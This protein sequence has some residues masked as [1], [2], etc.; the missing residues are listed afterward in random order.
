M[1]PTPPKKNNEKR[2]SDWLGKIGLIV[3]LGIALLWAYSCVDDLLDRGSNSIPCPTAPENTYLDQLMAIELYQN[4][5]NPEES[6]SGFEVDK[7]ERFI[8]SV[9]S[10][11]PPTSRTS[12]AHYNAIDV[13][14]KNRAL[15]LLVTGDGTDE[16]IAFTMGALV[17][18]EVNLLIAIEDICSSD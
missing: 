2:K 13:A 11:T 15:A 14:Y 3:F 10:L 17:T 16:E 6:Y 7:A 8:D 4:M 1:V 18:D 5:D 9:L 12:R